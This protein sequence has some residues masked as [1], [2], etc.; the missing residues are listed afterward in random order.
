MG[1]SPRDTCPA[2][3]L[4]AEYVSPLS[5]NT[6]CFWHISICI[7]LDQNSFSRLASLSIFHSINSFQI[8]QGSSLMG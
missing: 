8:F 4:D 1:E 2:V 6:K 5:G 7:V 3:I